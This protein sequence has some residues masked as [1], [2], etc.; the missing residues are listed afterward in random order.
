MLSVTGSW[1]HTPDSRAGGL[2]KLGRSRDGDKQIA[3]EEILEAELENERKEGV[4]ADSPTSDPHN[5]VDRY[6]VSW[7]GESCVT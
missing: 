3:L 5:Y 2:L 1:G 7:D 4:G 6:A